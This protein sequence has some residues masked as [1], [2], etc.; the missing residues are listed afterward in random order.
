MLLSLL[1]LAAAQDVHTLA[2]PQTASLD[3]SGSAVIAGEVPAGIIVMWSGDASTIPEGWSLCDGSRSTPDLS[4][5][6]VLGAGR[7]DIGATGGERSHSHTASE[8]SHT[9]DVPQTRSTNKAVID[10]GSI[11]IR[12]YAAVETGSDRGD[13]VHL[14]DPDPTTSSSERASISQ[15]E[16]LPP[17]YA[18]AFIMKCSNDTAR[19]TP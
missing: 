1:S 12:V 6:F 3:L 10:G 4:G 9:V 13:H 16:H 5:R 19:C 14:V 18:L 8:H 2:A 7:H 17:Y 15:T 11:P